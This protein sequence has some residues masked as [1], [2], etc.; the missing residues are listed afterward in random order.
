V[1]DLN[2]LINGTAVG[3]PVHIQRL[4]ALAEEALFLEGALEALPLD[5]RRA[6]KVWQKACRRTT[7]R[8]DALDAALQAHNDAE[9][10]LPCG[11]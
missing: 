10:L 11:S 9:V 1:I 2:D 5:D 3:A 6:D 4:F 8:V 7:R